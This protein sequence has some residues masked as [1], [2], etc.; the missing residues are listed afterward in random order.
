[1]KIIFL[2][3]CFHFLIYASETTKIKVQFK[4]LDQFEFAGFYAAKELGYYKDVGI[5]VNI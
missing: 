4:W 5:D 1:M 2:I 3:F